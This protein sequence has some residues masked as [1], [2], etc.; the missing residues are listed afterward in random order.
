MSATNNTN[1][2]DHEM[3]AGH[4]PCDEAGLTRVFGLLGKRWNGMLIWALLQGGPARFGELRHRVPDISERVLSDRLAELTSA[5]LVSRK[6]QEGPPV[7]VG[8]CL[9][10]R[11]EG[12]Q[13]AL[14]ELCHWSKEFFPDKSVARE[15]EIPRTDS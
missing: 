13:P 12:L 2:I 3:D 8:Y 11:G 9:T 10:E 5:G 7:A 15:G 4:D 6:V 14:M 1:N